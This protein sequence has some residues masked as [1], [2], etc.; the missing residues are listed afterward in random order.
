[1]FKSDGYSCG[2]SNCYANV[3]AINDGGWKN[4]RTYA[5]FP[6]GDMAGKKILNANMHGYFKYGKNG[7]TDGRWIAMGHANCIGYWCQ[8]N[9]IASTW[10]GTD[11]DLNFT[12][13]LQNAIAGD[14]GAVWSFGVKKGRIRAL[15]HIMTLSQRSTTTPTPIAQPVEPANGRVT[16]SWQP[17]LRLIAVADADGDAVQY[18]FR[19]I[20]QPSQSRCGH[21]PVEYLR[22]NGQYLTVYCR[23]VLLITGTYT[24]GATQADL[25]GYV[26][27]KD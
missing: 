8:G 16:P 24:L 10:A 5:Q 3:R 13:E 18:Y 20:N 17:V 6:Y 2:A 23:K 14:Y 25:T 27:S 11:F 4:W 12:G 9:Q 1:M 7:I 19:V 21:I 26:H 22:H 15:S